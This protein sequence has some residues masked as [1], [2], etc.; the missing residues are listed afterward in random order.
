MSSW[1]IRYEVVDFELVP[2][3]AFGAGQPAA[4]TRLALAGYV[5]ALCMVGSFVLYW[6]ILLPIVFPAT[7]PTTDAGKKTLATVRD[8][9][10]IALCLYSGVACFAT[11]HHMHSNNQIPWLTADGLARFMCEPVEGTWLRVLSVTFTLS[12]I[13]EWVD[14][15]FIVWL[16]N[17]P[18]GFL[19]TYHH[20]TTFWLFC[21][22]M[23]QPGSE[24]SGMLF[25]GF[26]HFL[27]YSHY[28]RS[29]PKPLVPLITI[30]QIMQLFTVLWIYTVNHKWCPASDFSADARA[31][32]P[33]FLSSYATVPVFLFFFIK[34][35]VERWVCPKPKKEKQSQQPVAKKTA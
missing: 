24:K 20:A 5:P 32:S 13:W 31:L 1:G 25:N 4:P 8:L 23:N 6:F 33:E 27:M 30:L 19:H 22:I 2:A 11:L 7:R 16:G 9:H 34:F 14:T 29:W 3:G 26:V 21:I 18:P 35:F 12:K 28:F 17:R 10:N 15:A